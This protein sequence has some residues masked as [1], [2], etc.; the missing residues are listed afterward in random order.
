MPVDSPISSNQL[1]RESCLAIA[2]SFLSVIFH[3][4][5]EG[6]QIVIWTMPDKVSRFS[7]RPHSAAVYAVSRADT[8]DAY[9]GVACYRN[10]IR[11]GRG[12]QADVIAITCVWADIDFAR[13]GARKG[14]PP[15]EA[16]GRHLIKAIGVRPSIIVH[17]GHGF[18]VY[19]LLKEPL[20]VGDGAVSFAKRWSDTAALRGKE[21]GFVIDSVGDLTRVLRVPGTTNRK[22][23]NDLRDVRIIELDANCRYSVEELET[24]MIAGGDDQPAKKTNNNGHRS[25]AEILKTLDFTQK[26]DALCAADPKFRDTWDK[27]RTDLSDQSAS[28]YDL[29]LATQASAAGWTEGEVSLLLYEFRRRHGLDVEKSLRPDYLTRT[30]QKARAKRPEHPNGPLTELWAARRLV[31]QYGQDLRY[32]YALG[33]MHWNRRAWER[34]RTGEVMRRA[35][36]T[37]RSMYAAAA[38]VP[39]R[40]QREQLVTFAKSC[41]TARKLRAIIALAESEPSIPLLPEKLDADPWLLNCENGTLDLRTGELRPPRREDYLTKTTGIAYSPEATAPMFHRFLQGVFQNDKDMIAFVQR[42]VGHALT[43]IIREH[44]LHVWRGVGQNGKSTLAEILQVVL[45]DY[46]MPAAPGLLI[47]RHNDQHPTERAELRGMRLV[48][49]GES[50]DGARLDEE[51]VKLLTGGD[52]IKGRYMRQDFFFFSPTHKLVLFTNHKPIIRGNDVGIWR[53]I[54]LWPFEVQFKSR[55]ECGSGDQIADGCMPENLKAERAGILAWLVQ[56]CLAWQQDGLSPPE[57]VKVATAKYRTESDEIG[58][59]LAACTTVGADNLRVGCT[60]L[61]N[62]YRSWAEQSGFPPLNQKRFGMAMSERGYGEDMKD[63][64]PATRRERY[65]GI[66]LVATPVD[67]ETIRNH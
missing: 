46:A 18:H 16:A 65:K 57:K 45:G 30:L 5:P 33:W 49:C 8:C 37:V 10:G 67:S 19:W 1:P 42:A 25:T 9:F 38:D 41:E 64:H 7:E 34:D 14:Y 21:L 4:Q 54:M 52:R 31:E 51:K 39:D 59:F 13:P 53:R 22:N 44:I 48:V 17:S 63:H 32:C 26:V 6:S 3:D 28:A 60:E 66:G 2:E 23:A 61:Y 62:A 20:L 40:E 11:S 56:G 27:K 15:D 24:Y 50:K 35:K 55:H 12:R 43:G 29:S 47:E 36:D 58:L